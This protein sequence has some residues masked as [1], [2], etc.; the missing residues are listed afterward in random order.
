MTPSL[1]AQ[2]IL[3]C[4]CGGIAA[5][6]AIELVRRLRE[7]GAEVQVAMTENA[8]R[9]VGAASLQ[10]VS[11][12]PVRDSL[13]DAAAEAA[14]GHIELARWA[15]CILVAPAT[16]DMLA[17]LAHGFADD[18]VTT[19]CLA[20]TAPVVVAPAMNNRMWLHPATQTNL[21]TLT[22]RGVAVIGPDHG[23]QACGEFGPGR[24]SE[25]TDIVTALIA[26]IRA[27][28]PGADAQDFVGRRLLISAGPTFEDLDPVRF[29]GNRSS[30]K[31]G[32]AIAAAAA[33]RGAEV[34]LVAGPVALPAPAGVR[35]IDVR[36]A[37]Q[38][39]EAVLAE[40]PAD[41]YIGAAAVADYTPRMVASEK[42]KKTQQPGG[43][44]TLTV[45]LV[46]TADVLAEVA[47]HPQRPRVVVGF[48]AETNDVE[49]YARDKLV[50]KRLDLVA[51]NRVGIAG[52]GFESEDNAL[53]VLSAER[54]YALGPAPKT[55]LADALLDLIR[56]RIANA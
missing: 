50:R 49:R 36:S 11:G 35:R 48:A 7:A 43:G 28:Y 20:T 6:K 30:G 27:G 1:A 40:L 55:A 21:A 16:A 33:R 4:V 5:Y 31:M 42:I 56:A 23:A 45:E 53:T 46:R 10:A 37:A 22:A 24:L 18:L 15:D 51:A 2:R 12:A 26:Q 39:R 9:F 54:A 3:L 13:W 29:I 17:R 19:L 47:A 52:S 32:F 14:M 38:M 25:P 44:E 8:K 34:V 41:V